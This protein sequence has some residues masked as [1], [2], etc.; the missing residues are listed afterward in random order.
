MGKLTESILSKCNATA[1]VYKP[2]QLIDLNNPSLAEPIEKLDAI[3]KDIAKLL[4]RK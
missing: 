2:A 4:K 3:G 1:F